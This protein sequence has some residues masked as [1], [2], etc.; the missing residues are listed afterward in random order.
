MTL[1]CVRLHRAMEL[2]RVDL[3]TKH[4]LHICARAGDVVRVMV[5]Q[6][7]HVRKAMLD[8]FVQ[9]VGQDPDQPLR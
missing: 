9:L 1:V 8:L 4:G 6:F 5:P 7:H 3:K 2:V